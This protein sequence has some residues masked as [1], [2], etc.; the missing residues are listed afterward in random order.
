MNDKV[1]CG[2]ASVVLQVCS[3]GV[4]FNSIFRGR[5]RPHAFSWLIWAAI[6]GIGFAAQVAEGAGPGSWARGFSAATCLMLAVLG[7]YKGE[8]NI[9]RGDWVTL[10]VAFSAIPLWV[11]TKTPVWSVFIVCIIDTIGYAPTLRKSWA[12][13]GEETPYSYFI[14]TACAACAILAVDNYTLSTWLYSAVLVVTNSAMGAVILARRAA[15]RA[16][17]AG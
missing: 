10:A 5:T 15:L 13:P 3:R 2:L 8:K 1:F 7:Y 9:T 17:A 6:S 4:Y 14:S 11:I 12:K 16:E